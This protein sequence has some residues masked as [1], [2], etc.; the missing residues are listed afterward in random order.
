MDGRTGHP[1]LWRRILRRPV[2]CGDPLLRPSAAGLTEPFSSRELCL[3]RLDDQPPAVF[4]RYDV[5]RWRQ[6]TSNPELPSSREMG[7]PVP[8]EVLVGGIAGG[9]DRVFQTGEV[10]GTC[11]FYSVAQSIAHN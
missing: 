10:E 4:W 6:D 1:G 11:S 5:G 2:D 7:Q 3:Q 9:P 8:G